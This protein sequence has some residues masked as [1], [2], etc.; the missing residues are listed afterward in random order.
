EDPRGTLP[1]VPS[2]E[3]FPCEHCPSFFSSAAFLEKHRT[4]A[5]QT[6]SR[7]ECRYCSYT[8][9][10]TT[11]VIQH[12]RTHT[13]ERPFVCGMCNKAFTQQ[14]NLIR[15][16]RIHNKEKPYSCRL[17]GYR[18]NDSGRVKDHVTAV[19]LKDHP[20]TCKHSRETV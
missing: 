7:R 2:L 10:S 3:T 12:E 4:L 17:C 8:S 1:A 15:H 18:S 5:H 11:K 6:V 9:E 14:S 13:G 16:V 19:H 20:H